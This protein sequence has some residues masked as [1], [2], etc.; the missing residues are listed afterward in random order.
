MSGPSFLEGS[1]V[2]KHR[3]SRSGVVAREAAGREPDYQ[4]LG[5]KCADEW[6]E[7]Q[8]LGWGEQRAC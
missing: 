6:G 8:R 1:G 3:A 2:D 5:G 7:G 4:K